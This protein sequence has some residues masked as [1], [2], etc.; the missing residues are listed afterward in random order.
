[1]S[2]ASDVFLERLEREAAAAVPDGPSPEL[3][4]TLDCM[5]SIREAE[6]AIAQAASELQEAGAEFP[7]P[8]A[9]AD[10]HPTLCR[11][12]AQLLTSTALCNELLSVGGLSGDTGRALQNCL[13][14]PFFDT[15]AVGFAFPKLPHAADMAEQN[16]LTVLRCLAC[17][18]L[19][20]PCTPQASSLAYEQASLVI[21]AVWPAAA[22]A[23]D[24]RRRLAAR[25]WVPELPAAG[26]AAPQLPPRTPAAHSLAA[27]LQQHC[28]GISLVEFHRAVLLLR[29]KVAWHM[30]HKV[31]ESKALL[32]DCQLIMAA[33]LW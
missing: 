31:E 22:G 5:R 29:F 20:G 12:L 27:D 13:L 32:A 17:V 6:A 14:K 21:D 28:P 24:A 23:R 4:A 10:G 1:M 2:L 8:A 9:T 11:G 19:L 33:R 26:A 25:S 18:L 30:A 3:L 16:G 7:P 15:S